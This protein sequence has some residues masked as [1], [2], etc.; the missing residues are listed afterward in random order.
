MS[1]SAGTIARAA[2]HPLPGRDA[3]M[4]LA[5]IDIGSNSVH[6][7][8][9]GVAPYGT[10]RVLGREKDMVRLG[11]KTLT[12]G[13]LG[14]RA[15]ERGLCTLGRFRRLADNHGVERILAVA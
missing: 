10:F 12:R 3:L 14:R 2:A 13:R 6:M 7:V 15:M 4:K 1:C 8:I 11:A 9:V 5:A